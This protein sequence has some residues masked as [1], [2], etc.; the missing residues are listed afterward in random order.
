V[1]V[2]YKLAGVMLWAAMH[3]SRCISVIRSIRGL[4]IS[5]RVEEGNR[6][7]YVYTHTD[8]VP[9][10]SGIDTVAVGHPSPCTV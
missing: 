3:N 1:D 10:S 2:A 7:E 9:R 8:V 5:T 6:G 4:D